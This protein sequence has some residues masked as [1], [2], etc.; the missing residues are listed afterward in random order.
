[1]FLLQREGLVE[2]TLLKREVYFEFYLLACLHSLFGQGRVLSWSTNVSQKSSN[3]ENLRIAM[4]RVESMHFRAKCVT[5]RLQYAFCPVSTNYV[6][7]D[8]SACLRKGCK[9]SR[10][11]PDVA[12][13]CRAERSAAAGLCAGWLYLPICPLAALLAC[14]VQ[15]SSTSRRAKAKAVQELRNEGETEPQKPYELGIILKALVLSSHT[16]YRTLPS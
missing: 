10:S 1:M 14:D 2:E 8:G 4:E 5:P 3:P 9:P 16:I 11:A 15:S 13:Q 12:K 6:I 7:R